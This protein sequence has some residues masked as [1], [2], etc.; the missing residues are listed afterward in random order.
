LFPKRK[1]AEGKWLDN[2]GWTTW[3]PVPDKV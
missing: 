2:N 1:D 3:S